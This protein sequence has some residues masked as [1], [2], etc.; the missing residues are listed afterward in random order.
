MKIAVLSAI[1]AAMLVLTADDG[2]AQNKCTAKGVMAGQKFELAECAVAYYAGS[3]G[4]TIWFSSTPITADERSTF[5]LSS[6]N[7]TFKRGRT[8]VTLGFCPGGGS[9]TPSPAKA[10]SV[11]IAFRHATVTD[12]GPQDQWVLEPKT[13]KQIKVERLTGELKKSGKLAG[14][15]TGAIAKSAKPFSWDLQFDLTLPQTAAGAGPG[16]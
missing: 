2:F 11:E 6:T 4:V 16:C 3:N 7:D 9:P 1:A 8:M 13:D 12:L 5:Q 15:I 14:K 10:K